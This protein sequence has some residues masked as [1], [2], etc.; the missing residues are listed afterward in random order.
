MK[1]NKAFCRCPS[2]STSILTVTAGTSAP[3]A[4]CW[5]PLR[6]PT[7][8]LRKC[9]GRSRA[10]QPCWKQS[11]CP[12]LAPDAVG[13]GWVVR[14]TAPP[15]R[16]AQGVRFPACVH[17]CGQWLLGLF[18]LEGSRSSAPCRFAAVHG[19]RQSVSNLWE[20]A[21]STVCSCSAQ[22]GECAVRLAHLW[23]ASWDFPGD[24]VQ[25]LC[26]RQQGHSLVCSLEQQEEHGT[27]WSLP[28]VHCT[29]SCPARGRG[30]RQ[31]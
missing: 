14:A 4:V 23:P 7:I 1:Q 9:L 21:V 17:F 12:P 3:S 5:T 30:A 27:C 24:G 16:W 22:Q 8:C 26:Y 28:W 29:F 19:K 20:T 15:G 18:L 10:R 31:A 2:P 13:G 11:C 25:P 6:T